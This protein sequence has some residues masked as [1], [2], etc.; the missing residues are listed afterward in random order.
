MLISTGVLAGA[1]RCAEPS[2]C[3]RLAM[4]LLSENQ[5]VVPST[6]TELK[7]VCK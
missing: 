4:P 3:V 7:M 2:E 1:G 5:L 6:R